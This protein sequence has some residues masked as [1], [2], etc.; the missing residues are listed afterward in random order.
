MAVSADD[1][2]EVVSTDAGSNTAVVRYRVWCY[3]TGESYNLNEQT[4]YFTIDGE[5]YWDSYT[6]PKNSETK[7]FDDTKTIYNASGKSVSASYSFPTTP[8]GGTKT[9]SSSITIPE[10]PRYANIT[11][12]VSSKS[13]NSVT[14]NWTTDAN[15]DTFQYKIGSGSWVNAETNINKRSGSFTIPNLSPNTSYKISF[16]AKRKDSQQWSTHGGIDAYVNVKTYDYGKISSVGNFNHGD[17]ASVVV[18]N[19]S[20]ATLSLKMKIGSTEILTTTPTAGTNTISFT[21][22]QLDQIY[23]LYGSSNTQTATF[24]LSTGT[25]TD[26]KNATITLTGNQKTVHVSQGRARVY[27]GVNGTVKPAVVW[28][29]NNGNRRCI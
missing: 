28:V 27:V 18:T 5:E 4:G 10:L 9:G 23:R 7:V 8:A 2:L 1:S 16:D 29:G 15:V 12:S 25:Y 17:N 24:V 3:T 22:S 19:P 20:G 14:I 6:L 11:A 26:S 21:Q 13:Y